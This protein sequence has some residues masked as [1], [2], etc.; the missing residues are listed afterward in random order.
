VEEGKELILNPTFQR[1]SVWQPQAKVLLIDTIL[2]KMP[3]P[4]V[5]M[6][7]QINAKTK[8]SVREIVDGQQRLRAI[9]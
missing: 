8:R 3:V 4:K 2:R 9:L 6:R 7:T 5:Y 1:R